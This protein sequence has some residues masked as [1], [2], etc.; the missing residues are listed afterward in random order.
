MRFKTFS[1]PHMAPARSVNRVMGQVLLALIPGTAAMTWYFGWGVLINVSLA[2]T[3]ALACEA[4]MLLVRGRTLTPHI[5]DLSAVLAGWLFALAVPPLTPWWVTLVGVGFAMVVAKHLYG[6]LGYNPFNPAMVGY[7]VVLISF[8]RE[9][10]LWLSPSVIAELN[11]SLPQTFA[12]IFAGTLPD[13]LT[14]DMITAATPLDRIQTGVGLAHPIS[15]IQNSPFFGYLGGV[16]WEWIGLWF[17]VG[18]LWLLKRGVIGWQ[19]PV[20]MLGTLTL[21]SGLFWLINPETYASPLFHVF[22]GAAILGAFF[23]ATDPVSASTTPRGRLIF[24]A[25]VGA[26]VFVIRTWGGYAEGVAFAVLLM[27]MMVPLIDHYTQPRVFG[28][29]TAGKEG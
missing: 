23:I 8:P 9:M 27:N 21:L 12:A 18:G 19:I 10:T 1:S 28:K 20:A 13:G 5:T 17:L 25:G 3:V 22:S 14:W 11:L 24:G 6:G 15:E 26:L 29:T 16:G 7:V 2:V 4:L